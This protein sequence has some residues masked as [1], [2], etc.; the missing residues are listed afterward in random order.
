[1]TETRNP[2]KHPAEVRDRKMVI[3]GAKE[4][5]NMTSSDNQPQP[6]KLLYDKDEAA[7]ILGLRKTSIEWLL[8]TGKIPHRKVSGKIRFTID[9]LQGLIRASAVTPCA[10]LGGKEGE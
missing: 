9:D 6:P 8:R 3:G 7:Q 5:V 4:N 1:M 2:D 10:A